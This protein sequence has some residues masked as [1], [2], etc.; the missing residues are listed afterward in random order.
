MSNDEHTARTRL[1]SAIALIGLSLAVCACSTTGGKPAA[2]VEARDASGF[3][4][5]ETAR[6]PAR[7]RD[8]FA[9]AYQALEAGDL[10]R[11]ITLLEEITQSSPELTA[12]QINLGIAYQRKGDLA[13][14]ETALLAALERNPRHP[15]AQNELGIVYRRMGRFADARA[16]FETALSSHPEFHPARRNLGILCD[17]YLSDPTCALEQYELYRSAM[18]GDEKVEMWIADLRHRIGG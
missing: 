15:V 16:R 13:Q 7:A 9:Q 8:D 11:A 10:A 1:G 2:P 17:L 12:A 4:I 6:V 18:P 5:T 3:S 14:A